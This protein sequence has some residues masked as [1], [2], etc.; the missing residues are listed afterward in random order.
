VS[1]A[2]LDHVLQHYVLRTIELSPNIRTGMLPAVTAWV[3]WSAGQRGLPAGSL[4]ALT[5]RVVELDQ[6]FDT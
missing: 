5:S 3:R 1:P 6:T 2:W 4:K